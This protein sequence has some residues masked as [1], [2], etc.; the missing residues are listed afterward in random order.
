[1]KNHTKML[2]A[3][4]AIPPVGQRRDRKLLFRKRWARIKDALP[5]SY[6]VIT[7]QHFKDQGIALDPITMR[8]CKMYGYEGSTPANPEGNWPLLTYWE[9]L[10]DRSKLNTERQVI[11]IV[12]QQAATR[13]A[14]RT[15]A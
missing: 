6:G 11:Q 10:A 4:L 12:T 5:T 8:N 1:M 7:L 13:R 9:E 15:A 2:S 14:Q 3:P